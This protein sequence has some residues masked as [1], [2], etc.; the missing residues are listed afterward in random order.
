MRAALVLAAG[1]VLP[2]V[3]PLPAAAT[4]CALVAI[5][6]PVGDAVITTT[7]RA[8]LEVSVSGYDNCSSTA[9][10]PGIHAVSITAVNAGRDSVSTDL[11]LVSGTS[12]A[13]V[14]R[15][16]LS[17]TTANAL[18]TWTISVRGT[19][20]DQQV[21]SAGERTF[22]L[23]RATRL[24]ADAG[25]EPVTRGGHVTVAG[26][27]RR[28]N[29]DLEYRPMRDR[30]VRVYFQREGSATKRLMGRTQ[31][32]RRGTFHATFEAR[33]SG[34]WLVFFPGTPH[35]ASRW[36]TGDRVWLR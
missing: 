32:D 31:T 14:W 27:L 16:V 33:R 18:G 29:E 19:D 17:F 21:N 24:R 25:P 4:T 3:A 15:G 7:G 22:T 10:P 1:L 20:A 28:L 12:R 26:K 34:T 36:S 30:V 5:A 9:A 23:K 11:Q 13:G 35:Y 2:L 6:D 8:A